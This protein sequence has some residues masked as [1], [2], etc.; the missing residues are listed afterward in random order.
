M[1]SVLVVAMCGGSALGAVDTPVD[2]A[3]PATAVATTA[4]TT[5]PAT[6]PV[7]PPPPRSPMIFGTAAPTKANLIAQEQIAGR[8]IVA[9]RIYRLWGEKLFGPDQIWERDTYHTLFLSIKPR[10]PDGTVIPWAQ[11]AAAQPGSQ[12]YQDMQDM[13]D[14][15]K[16]YGARVFLTF[17]HEPEAM[18][19]TF[20]TGPELRR[21]VPDLRDRDARRARAQHGADRD[22]HRLR[23]HQE[24]RPERQPVLPG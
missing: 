12:I 17:N 21:R 15:I 10:R 16:A 14:Q 24:G 5:P 4:D 11:I 19:P 20:G 8:P 7:T 3:G 13:A 23:L 22:L 2:P 9:V 1:A 6:A 18:D